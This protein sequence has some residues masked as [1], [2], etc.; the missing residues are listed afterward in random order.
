LTTVDHWPPGGPRILVSDSWLANAGDAAASLGTE[1]ML[2]TLFP[3]AS[4]VHAAYQYEEIGPLLGELLCTAPLEDLIGTSW[5]PPAE[6]WRETG[7]R[8]VEDAD[9]VV[10]QAG[11]AL[12]EAY[13]PVARLAALSKV[14]DRGI[15]IVML[16]FTLDLFTRARAR[17]DLGRVLRSSALVAVR[18]LRSVAVAESLGA[19]DV[20][21]GTDPALF[22]FDD[23]PQ[24]HTRSQ[25]SV[26]LTQHHPVEDRRAA[27]F[28]AA[29]FVLTE[30]AQR[31]RGEEL[32][33]WSTVQGA[34][35]LARED[36]LA[37]ARSVLE[38]LSL[39]VSQVHLEEGYIAPRRAI[40]MVAGSRALVS[41]R[42][43]PCLFAACQNTPFA[44]MLDGQRT[45]VLA[46]TGL[47]ERIANP[48]DPDG[49]RRVIEAALATAPGSVD[50]GG[51]MSVLRRR[52]DVMMTRLGAVIT[53]G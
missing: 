48:F 47:E 6:R 52:L 3:D 44:L 29:R 45:G 16:G 30:V 7:P 4:I 50:F 36:D 40:D 5:S 11:G 25:V 15:P 42:M 43:H 10:C 41:M 28:E 33:I 8:L 49:I 27:M 22:L 17:R 13:Q 37:V 19:R 2:R 24:E 1:A 31:C 38:R 12:V 35:E 21:L 46:G 23:Q 20:L 26:L 14:V 34:P 32:H 53:A 39:P 51:N 18:D 9:A